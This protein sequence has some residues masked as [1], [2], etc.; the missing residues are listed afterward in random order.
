MII[1]YRSGPSIN[2]LKALRKP[3]LELKELEKC[4]NVD[5]LV[6]F[7]FKWRLN[8]KLGAIIAFVSEYEPMRSYWT[9]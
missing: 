9:D 8:V 5:F 6:T 2:P 1:F 7:L 4:G 3:K